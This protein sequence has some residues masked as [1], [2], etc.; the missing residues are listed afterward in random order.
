MDVE[1]FRICSMCGEEKPIERYAYDARD[2]T[3]RRQCADCRRARRAALGRGEPANPRWRKRGK[4]ATTLDRYIETASGCWEHVSARRSDGYCMAR[5]AGKR[6]FAHRLA[7]ELAHGPIPA[8]M[9]VCHHCDNPPCVNPVHL[10]LGT[11]R[12]NMADMTRKRRHM[13][14]GGGGRGERNPGTRLTA[15]QVLAIRAR[16][17]RGESIRVLA[18]EYGYTMNGMRYVVRGKSWKYVA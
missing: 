6:G 13:N 12:D 5:L 10:F 2:G 8:G 18:D 17:A 14:V 3:R 9:F 7:W 15:E 16:A 1:K 11:H 4:G